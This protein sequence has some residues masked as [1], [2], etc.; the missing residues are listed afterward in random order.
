MSLKPVPQITSCWEPVRLISTPDESMLGSSKT[1]ATGP[2]KNMWLPL[3]KHIWLL[4]LAVVIEDSIHR[5][6]GNKLGS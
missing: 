4:K 2:L 5:A 3:S 6:S 1:V